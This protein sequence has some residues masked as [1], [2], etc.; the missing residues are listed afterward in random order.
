ML[1]VRQVA[2]LLITLSF[3]TVPGEMETEVGGNQTEEILHHL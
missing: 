2:N 1:I 3:K